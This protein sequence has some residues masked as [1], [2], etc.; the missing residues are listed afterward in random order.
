MLS[1]SEKGNLRPKHPTRT[2]N[3]RRDYIT[4]PTTNMNSAPLFYVGS[5][6]NTLW[7]ST[8]PVSPLS[9]GVMRFGN[10]Y[11]LSDVFGNNRQV[12]GKM[13]AN[14]YPNLNLNVDINGNYKLIDLAGKSHRIYS[15]NKGSYV[16]YNKQQFYL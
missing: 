13:A 2:F 3:Q 11:S 16:K 7:S 15:N 9:V 8:S 12:K 10:T 4:S 5:R 6:V 1:I 14:V